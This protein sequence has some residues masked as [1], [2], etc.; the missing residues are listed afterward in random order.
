VIPLP[1]PDA[2]RAEVGSIVNSVIMTR[3]ADTI[4]AF[5]VFKIVSSCLNLETKKQT[6][7][8]ASD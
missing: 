3:S 6:D 4:L 2:A 1:V 8:S 7:R 5:H